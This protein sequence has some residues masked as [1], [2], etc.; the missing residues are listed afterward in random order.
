MLKRIDT[1]SQ[2]EVKLVKRAGLRPEVA[3]GGMTRSAAIADDTVGS[4]AIFTVVSRV[5][6]GLRSSPHVHLNCESSIY[7]ASGHGRVITGANLDHSL[8]IEPGDFLFVPPDAPHI[9]VNDSDT[10]LVLVVSRNTSEE[11]VKDY[12]PA[13]ERQPATGSRTP[14]L[15]RPMLLD[16][17]KTCRTPIRGKLS[18]LWRVRGVRPYDKNPQ[19]CNRCEKRI[20]GSEDRV[21]TILFA[22]I[23]D[24]SGTT[25]RSSNEETLAMLRTFFNRAAPA[26]YGHY[27]VIDQFL[28]DGMK[29]LFNV[30]APRVSHA[31]DALRA[32]LDIQSNLHDAPF[33]IG[34]GIDTGMA[35]TGHIGLDSVVDFTCVGEA[36]NTAARLQTLAGPGQI[37][38]GPT[39]WRKTSELL[40]TVGRMAINETVDVK[41]MGE[42]EIHRVER[43]QS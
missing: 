27:G 21:V 20:H 6:P 39:A 29:V 9:V 12:Q 32:A 42:L 4:T 35:L 43:S 10:D 22:D 8:I 7:V 37:I 41:G 3:S 5:P 17:C 15:E 2:A 25:I 1:A 30:P 16:R 19:L 11:R 36:V 28:G 14:Q 38:V 18:L 24:Y 13:G 34:I 40:S 26:V 33:G 23:R 31:E